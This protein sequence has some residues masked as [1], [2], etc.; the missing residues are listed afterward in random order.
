M[1]KVTIHFFIYTK[2]DFPYIKEGLIKYFE[3]ENDMFGKKSFYCGD[4][5]DTFHPIPWFRRSNTDTKIANLLNFKIYDSISIF[6][7]YS[8]PIYPSNNLI[9][10]CGHNYSGFELEYE[11]FRHTKLYYGIL[12]RYRTL[13]KFEIIA[14]LSEDL[15]KIEEKIVI[16][17]NQTVLV[18]GRNETD[19][20]RSI[21]RNKF[22]N[23]TSSIVH[24]Y[25]RYPY[26]ED[27]S[28]FHHK[29]NFINPLLTGEAF[30]R[31][32]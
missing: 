10:I 28:F 16:E 31:I 11:N 12:T 8:I 25:S 4:E 32:N 6:G 23:Y 20:K 1:N 26:K 22:T 30:V 18:F 29:K 21:I 5:I 9:I 3:P 19:I 2:K 14:L 17:K 27:D 15:E 24:W 13:E 7:N